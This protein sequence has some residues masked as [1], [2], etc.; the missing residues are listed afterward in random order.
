MRIHLGCQ[1]EVPESMA[2]KSCSIRRGARFPGRPR[3]TA[4]LTV[5]EASSPIGC[6]SAPTSLAKDR[7]TRPLCSTACLSAGR[8]LGNRWSFRLVATSAENGLN[9]ARIFRHILLSSCLPYRSLAA[10]PSSTRHW[11]GRSSER[12]LRPYSAAWLS[13]KLHSALG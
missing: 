6:G 4:T 1:A 2:P 12:A 11:A 3:A 13:K 5:M 9:R 8:D 10:R 7:S